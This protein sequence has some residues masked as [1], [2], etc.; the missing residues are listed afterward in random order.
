[1]S[2]GDQNFL[3]IQTCVL[4]VHIH[5]D[6]CKQKVKKL[7]QKI[8][9]V[10]TVSIDPDHGKVTVSGS[11]DP[12][13]LIKKLSKSGK[14]AELLAPKGGSGNNNNNNKNNNISGNN[15][16]FLEQ[17]QKLKLEGGQSQQKDN[18]K[19][20]KGK[21]GDSGERQEGPAAS[22]EYVQRSEAASVE[23]L[24]LASPKGPE[25]CQVQPPRRF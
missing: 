11:V 6:G 1:M 13:T 14:H 18:G 20:Q 15:N 10:Y 5:C 16:N 17:L 22:S 2:K 21:G 19:P 3:K 4:K 8:D 7:L 25:E 24:Q 12:S 9:G 23:G